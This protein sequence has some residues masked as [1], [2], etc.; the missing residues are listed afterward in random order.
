MYTLKIPPRILEPE[1][2]LSLEE[3]RAYDGLV[4]KYLKVLHFG[5]LETIINFSP[6]KGLFLDIGTGTGHLAIELAKLCPD[7]HIIAVDL[8]DNMLAVAQENAQKEGVHERIKFM[9]ADAKKLPFEDQTF[10]CVYCHNMLHHISEPIE[11]LREIKR[12]VKEDAA[13][14][15]RDLIRLSPLERALHVNIFGLTYDQMMKKEYE[16]SIKA[17]LSKEEWCELAQKIL[18]PGSRITYQFVTH[19]S[20]ERPAINRR[21]NYFKVDIPP[22]IRIATSF[23]ISKPY[24]WHADDIY[25]LSSR[26]ET[27]LKAAIWAPSGDNLQPWRF[28]IKKED[29]IDFY[30]D[31][32]VDT[33]FFNFEQNASI[34]SVGAAL[35]NTTYWLKLADIKH[36]FEFTPNV[37]GSYHK[38]CLLKID[39]TD[40]DLDLNGFL[41]KSSILERC[42]NRKF[43]QK[44][45]LSKKEIESLIHLCKDI[46][47]EIE[48]ICDENL[49]E[50]AEIIYLAD[51]IRLERKDLH[52]FLY[53][54]IRWERKCL[55]RGCGIPIKTLEAGTAGEAALRFTRPWSVMKNMG[56]IGLFKAMAEHTKK[57]VL[58]SEGIITFSVEKP[59]IKAYF[60]VGRAC[61]RLWLRL[62]E[63]GLAA[64]PLA[65]APLFMLRWRAGR[66]FD[67]SAKHQFYMQ[68]IEKEWEKLNLKNTLM[69][70]RFGKAELPQAK[71]PRK[72][73]SSFI[74]GEG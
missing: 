54:T 44:I 20:L 24:D 62:T 27:L 58:S 71:A 8:S 25:S 3:V 43:Y 55:V 29:H 63:M 23:Y 39:W 9:K 70:L 32:L 57:L 74:L 45:D 1:V 12:V 36:S 66:W 72:E 28:K 37:T 40:R 60:D 34:F 6:E 4:R 30:Y 42:T 5:F 35:E 33:S 26:L 31:P 11:L 38:I 15:I 68:K 51:L 56:S 49:N 48:F 59:D 17:A 50:L 73:L 19:Q 41:Y 67:F 18:I 16:D 22:Q 53:D 47:V 69:F 2:M 13:I 52:E 21:K 10:D 46:P 61:Q 14:L 64:H 65:V 7:I